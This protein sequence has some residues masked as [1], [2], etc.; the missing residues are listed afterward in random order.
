MDKFLPFRALCWIPRSTGSR[1]FFND[2]YAREVNQDM[3]DRV[4][5][6]LKELTI[7]GLEKSINKV[8]EHKETLRIS[9]LI[10]EVKS[11]KL[12]DHWKDKGTTKFVTAIVYDQSFVPPQI[13]YLRLY[14]DP[15]EGSYQAFASVRISDVDV[16]GRITLDLEFLNRSV[17]DDE[18]AVMRYVYYILAYDTV[19]DLTSMV[20]TFDDE[21]LISS[22]TNKMVAFE[23]MA[24]IINKKIADINL[25]LDDFNTNL[26]SKKDPKEYAKLVNTYA[27]LNK[28]INDSKFLLDSAAQF[29]KKFSE[30]SECILWKAVVMGDAAQETS[31]HES[32]VLLAFEREMKLQQIVLD[33]GAYKATQQMKVLTIFMGVIAILSLCAALANYLDDSIKTPY[34]VFMLS[35]GLIVILYLL[36]FDTDRGRA[37][38]FFIAEKWKVICE[39]FKSALR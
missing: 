24:Q 5:R 33:Q 29:C 20:R 21:L 11:T 31:K 25:K 4:E 18:M 3:P 23:D 34:V 26:P 1:I 36:L 17:V 30:T 12:K 7:S 2:P 22:T 35:A 19:N 38:R 10:S 15:V 27:D 6:I 9:G 16:Q 13:I 14:K 39:W 8:V 28:T 37:F 32:D